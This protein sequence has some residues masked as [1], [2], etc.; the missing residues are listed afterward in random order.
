MFHI[1]ISLTVRADPLP[2]G[3]GAAGRADRPPQLGLLQ[4]HQGAPLAPLPA[5]ALRPGVVGQP[6]AEQLGEHGGGRSGGAARVAGLLL[7]HRGGGGA[8]ESQV[9]GGLGG[10]RLDRTQERNVREELSE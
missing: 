10:V 7:G 8:G 5:P 1:S 9:V 6:G 3:R 2:D 4:R